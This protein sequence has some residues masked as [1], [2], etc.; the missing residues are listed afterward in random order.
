NGHW[1][2][3]RKTEKSRKEDNPLCLSSSFSCPQS[4]LSSGGIQIIHRDVNAHAFV[5]PGVQG[6]RGGSGVSIVPA[7]GNA[8]MVEP[9]QDPVGRIE[10]FP[11]DVRDV[12]LHPGV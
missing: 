8:N 3:Y 4:L 2:F 9:G 7:V 10:T 1:R 5:C 6:S 11:A 12:Q